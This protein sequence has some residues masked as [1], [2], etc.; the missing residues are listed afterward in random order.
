MNF[1]KKLMLNRIQWTEA[2]RPRGA[3]DVELDTGEDGA[4]DEAAASSSKGKAKDEGET[5][6]QSLEDNKCF[7]IWEG[8]LRDRAFSNFRAKSCPTD[9]EARDLL[10][11]RLKGYWDVAK[12]WKPE[13]E[14]LY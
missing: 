1:Y 12:N 14:D 2:A 10:G 3:E 13:E 4:D 8:L 11:E 6:T 9:R 5:A 7:L